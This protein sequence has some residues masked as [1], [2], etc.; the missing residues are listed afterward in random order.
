MSVEK[1]TVNRYLYPAAGLSVWAGA[2][3]IIGIMVYRAPLDHSVTP[4]YHEAVAKWLAA[5][6]LYRDYSFHY[7][8][9]FVLFFLP[10]HSMPPAA[11]DILWRCISSGLLA[12]SLWRIIALAPDPRGTLFLCATWIALLPGLAA[13]RNG[14]A[15]VIFAAFTTLAAANLAR[16]RW[17]PASVYLVGAI[18][19]KGAIGLVMLLLAAAWY[20]PLV[21]RLALALGIFLVIPFLFYDRAYVL[22]QYQ[23]YGEHLR[24]LSVNERHFANAEELFRKFGIGLTEKASLLASIGA[25][26]ATLIAWLIGARRKTEPERAM[27]LLGLSTTYLMLFNPM[28]EINS[29]VIVAPVLAFYAVQAMQDR[30]NHVFG[31]GIAFI[32]L[33]I[34]GFPEI[35]RGF[36]R[37]LDLWWP[38]LMIA[39]FGALLV[40][41]IFSDRLIRST[42]EMQHLKTNL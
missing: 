20:R 18:A 30:R 13:M 9:Q 17:W 23:Q 1:I 35:F 27:L 7:P 38:P 31:Y 37:D 12:W 26:F 15:N 6:P 10:F 21:W 2:V 33:S 24:A 16:A 29:Y 25:G 32:G 28:T 11:G 22:S 42:Q 3:L 36:D 34:G 5:A 39:P 4:V 8:P 40:Y 19:A 14:Q 41:S